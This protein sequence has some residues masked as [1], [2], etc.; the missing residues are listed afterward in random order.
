VRRAGTAARALAVAILCV[1]VGWLTSAGTLGL[2]LAGLLAFAALALAVVVP[3]HAFLAL[4]LIVFG[5]FSLSTSHPLAFGGVLV[6]SAD[7]LLIVVL[8]RALLPR[9][10]TSPPTRLGGLPT[11]LF[12]A[13]VLVMTLAGV[14]GLLGGYDAVGV[15]RLATPLAYAVGFY[16][17]FARV[18]QEKAFDVDRAI[19]N[20]LLVASGFVAYMAYARITNSPF[21][22]DETVGRLGPVITTA[23]ELRRDYGFA[24]AFILYPLL[25]LGGA[26]YLLHASRRGAA[27]AAVAAVGIVSTFSTLIRGEIFGLVLGLVAIALLR[28]ES[29]LRGMGKLRAVLALVAVMVVTVP[30]L[31]TIDAS[32]TRGIVERSLPWFVTQTDT[33]ES[34]A[35]YRRQAVSAGFEAARSEPVGVGL[36][37][38]DDL[39]G[40]T[41]ITLGHV[42][43]SGV[44]TMLVYTG[45][46]GLVAAVL[47]IGGIVWASFRLPR[48]RPWLHPFFVGSM[49]MLTVYSV[50]AAGLVGQGWVTGLAALVAAL[51]FHA[52]PPPGGVQTSSPKR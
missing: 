41:S 37:P 3:P 49:V 1:Y 7:L 45:W 15:I 39:G 50:A 44:T 14:R 10:R 8:L 27:A 18:V 42:A 46:V 24:S 23:G 28:N 51:R 11:A 26:A 25:A 34:T 21:E 52:P 33:A 22:T 4:A 48:P 19:R 12:A 35:D 30:V 6:Y 43:H 16:V 9:E 40:E 47:A 5:T 31:W 2:E 29:A 17:G 20:L 36:V 13:W 38:A 32:L